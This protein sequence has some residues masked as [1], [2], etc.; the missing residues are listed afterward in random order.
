MYASEKQLQNE[1]KHL[2][3]AI[4]DL[5][6]SHGEDIKYLYSLISRQ[7]ETI[8]ELYDQIDFLKSKIDEQP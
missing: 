5:A 8:N 6:T 3:D 7:N 4:N 2:K 1:A